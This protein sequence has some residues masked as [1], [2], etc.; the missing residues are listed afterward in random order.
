MAALDSNANVT[1]PTPDNRPA[2]GF[3]PPFVL[4]HQTLLICLL[5]LLSVLFTFL[6]VVNNDFINYDDDIYVTTNPHVQNGL[7]W[8]SVKWAFQSSEAS[9]WHPLTWLSHM[10]DC[11]FYGLKPWGHHLTSLLLH[12]ANTLLL[13]LV[14]R[15]MTG[16]T[17]R[18]FFVAALF[19]LHPLRVESVA[20]VAERKDVL[21]T[22]FWLL[23]LWTY[24]GFV[25]SARSGSPRS[26]ISY[27]LTLL[28]FAL[29]LMSKPMLVNLPFV[30]L[31]LD[32]WPLQRFQ[33]G[34]VAP[35]L[36]E[37]IPFFALAAIASVI[38]FMVQ[39][40]G[41]AVAQLPL[42]VRVENALV[43]Y[44]RYLASLFHPVNLSVFYPHPL[45][46]RTA[47]VLISASL[48]TGISLIVLA[49]FRRRPF[50]PVGWFW[51]LG[52]LVPVIGLIQ[53][54]A[55]SMA[56][57]Y[58]YVPMIGILVLLTWSVHDLTKNWRP[59]ALV[60][61]TV[62]AALVIVCIPLT[63]RQIGYWK[64]S[65]TLFQHALAVTA[66]NHVA[67]VHLGDYLFQQK[68]V[69]QAIEMYHRSLQIAPD[70]I[71]AH[72]DLGNALLAKGQLDEGIAEFE[73]VLKINPA[74]PR[75]HSNL[76]VALFRKGRLDDA[77]AHLEQAVKSKP[78]F[79]DARANLG[80]LLLRKGRLDDGILE[81]QS[82]VKLNRS[83]ADAHYNL[84]VAL[85]SKNRLDEAINEFT[86]VTRLR[87]QDAGSYNALGIALGKE[88]R[89]DES[90]AAFQQAVRLTPDSAE[91]HTNLGTVL[92][93]TGHRD[94]A[95]LHFKQ[96]LKLQPGYPPAASQLRAL[97]SPAN[98]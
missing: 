10:L 93:A 18:S 35:L 2:P 45:Q 82:A 31:L 1:G 94:E 69:D 36:L 68:S 97:T 89:L 92:A 79:A 8:D 55:Q 84:A 71:D 32:Y 85:E 43:S 11:Q 75:A 9:N 83:D 7:T 48:I 95:I 59:Q 14:L 96:A 20:W 12:T 64:N 44:S 13:F 40:S 88:G 77:I 57:R 24:S 4:K 91:A 41:G 21:S 26:K 25:T 54:G 61:S 19:G 72:D 58:T 63:R 30:L 3:L 17:W 34:R 51:Y 65:S 66:H 47:T 53:V 98:P 5:L 56:D 15:R 37:K 38:T 67:Y 87:P 23:T 81:L 73:K 70:F 90:L 22:A 49:Q 6:P 16:A 74:H 39:K 28:F 62:G 52:T 42:L 76:G 50:L 33:A 78:D 60:L 46:W 27:G 29:G 80:D 86:A